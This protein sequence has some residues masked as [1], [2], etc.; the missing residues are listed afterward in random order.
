MHS[1]AV[2]TIAVMNQKGGVGKTTTV[3][4]LGVGLARLGRRVLLMD[5]D[6][7]AHLTASLGLQ[8][9]PADAVT[10]IDV[11]EGQASL[12]QAAISLPCDGQGSLTLAAGSLALSGADVLFASR[13]DRELLLKKALADLGPSDFD[14]ILLDCPPNLG[15]LTLNALCAAHGVLVPVQAE[16][17]ALQSLAELMRTMDAVRAQ[18]NP[19]LTLYGVVLTRFSR[20]KVL[21]REVAATLREHFPEQ[22]FETR[23]RENVALAEAPGFGQDIFRYRPGSAGAQDY[24]QLAKELL[25]KEA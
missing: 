15:V 5:L 23:I 7:Q 4:N 16:Y 9:L 8:E 11:L 17:L 2:R 12:R 25:R 6:A 14:Y 24:L 22:L 20:T 10:S 13:I 3:A 19:D 1:T 18:L 21:N